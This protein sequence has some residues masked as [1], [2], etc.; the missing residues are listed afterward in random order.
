MF[1]TNNASFNTLNI[2]YEKLAGEFQKKGHET[3]FID[4]MD[5]GAISELYGMLITAAWPEVKEEYDFQTERTSMITFIF[6]FLKCF[7][8]IP[9]I[10]SDIY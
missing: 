5:D 3:S 10:I 9:W 2:F 1:H 6:L 4:L 8:I 7:W